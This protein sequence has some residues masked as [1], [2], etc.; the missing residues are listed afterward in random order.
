[1]SQDTP[2]KILLEHLAAGDPVELEHYLGTLGPSERAR[3][4]AR[5][6]QES[7]DRIFGM[8]SPDQAA[9][10]IQD[11][12]DEQGAGLIEQMDSETAADVV[13]LLPINDQIDI[14]NEISSEDATRAIIANLPAEDRK[15]V[16]QLLKYHEDTA[17]GIMTTRVLSFRETMKVGDVLQDLEQN[18]EQY[19]EY[20]VQYVY[21]VDQE[22]RLKGVLPLRNLVLTPRDTVI[23]RV[24]KGEPVQTTV[25]TSLEELVDLFE[26]HEFLGIPVVD[27][28]GRLA[29]V[30][31][32]YEVMEAVGEREADTYLKSSGIVG[33]EE[34]RSM[35]LLVRSKRRLSWLSINILLNI[36]AASVIAAY[37]DTVAAVIALAVFL[38]IIS[39]MSGCSGNQAVAVSI[40]EITLGISKPSD[41]FNV[42]LKES[43]VGIIN[44]TVL[45]ILLGGVAFLWKGNIYLGLVIGGALL[46]NTIIAVCIGGSIPLILQKWG[47]D[48]ALASGPILTTVTD[49]CG[50]L[51]TLGFATSMLS[52]IH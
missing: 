5:L 50:F 20:D 7:I 12:S 1:M 8:I 32:R 44:G 45:G 9:E 28:R 33:G 25:D 14:L 42:I 43:I 34:L 29:G 15:E 37:Q 40:R 46:F 13:D 10:I 18:R 4:F 47:R 21:V 3:T 17:G 31:L 36:A 49:M 51:L 19:A 48:P 26:E 6:D 24:M 27:R 35:P 52:L 23:S 2:W 41:I 38:P 30:A 39:D 11:L 16:R 22:G